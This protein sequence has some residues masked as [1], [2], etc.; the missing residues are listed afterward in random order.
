MIVAMVTILRLAPGELHLAVNDFL[1][2]LSLADN[3]GGFS[4]RLG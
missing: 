2:P 1:Q 3:N 4:V